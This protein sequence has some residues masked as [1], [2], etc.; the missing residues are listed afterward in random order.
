M[1]DITVS[2][3]E[4]EIQEAFELRSKYE[5]AKNISN[6]E[7]EK[8]EAKQRRIMGMLEK[9]EMDSYKG[10]A[11]TFSYSLVESFKV[12]KDLEGRE[13]FFA[14][15]K[16]RGVYDTMISVNSRTLNAFAKEELAAA[17]NAGELDF[18]IPGLEKGDPSPKFVMRKTK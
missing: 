13:K 5:E 2:Q 11:G 3:L 4:A 18:Q 7:Y 14:F 8:L 15:L 16:E 17:E 1:S 12:P 9:L 10:K 6:Q